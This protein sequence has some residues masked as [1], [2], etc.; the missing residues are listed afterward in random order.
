VVDAGNGGSKLGFLTKLAIA[1]Q[2][3]DRFSL[4][5]FYG[6]DFTERCLVSVSLSR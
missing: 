5:K 6:E 1:L 3:G 2:G 4:Q